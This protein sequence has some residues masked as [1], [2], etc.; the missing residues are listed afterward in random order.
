MTDTMLVGVD[1][2]EASRRAVDFAATRARAGKA[3]LVVAYVIEWRS[4]AVMP[5]ASAFGPLRA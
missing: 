1:G 5:P 3:R 4:V 2:S